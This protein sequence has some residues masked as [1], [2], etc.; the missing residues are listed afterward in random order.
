MLPDVLNFQVK[1]EILLMGNLSIF[2][3]LHG[4]TKHDYGVNLNYKPTVL[5]SDP[6]FKERI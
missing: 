2:K 4:Q 5:T 3:I 6:M 1:L